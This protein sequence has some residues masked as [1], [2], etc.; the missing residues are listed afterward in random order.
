MHTWTPPSD[1][2]D[3]SPR[4]PIAGSSDYLVLFVR[5]DLLRRYPNTIVYANRAKWGNEGRE[6]D[7][8]A[9]DGNAIAPAAFT[10]AP[11]R[12]RMLAFSM[13]GWKCRS[14]S[15]CGTCLRSTSRT[16]SSGALEASG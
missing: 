4:P 9:T 5:G 8:P 13:S 14:S 16:A 12:T 2:K 11:E 10:S 1:L 3:H 15:R 7:D 6:I